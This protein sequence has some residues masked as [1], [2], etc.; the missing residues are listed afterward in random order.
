MGEEDGHAGEIEMTTLHTEPSNLGAST[1][2]SHGLLK[3]TQPLLVLQYFDDNS[4]EY[5]DVDSRSVFQ[6]VKTLL[7]GTL[8]L[9]QDTK[10]LFP[11]LTARDVRKLVSSVL[12]ASSDPT[13]VVRQ[14]VILLSLHP[15]NAIILKDSCLLLLQHGA[16]GILETFMDRFQRPHDKDDAEER[17]L[18]FEFRALDNILAAL[19]HYN[20]KHLGS[21][22]REA[23]HFIGRRMRRSI[24]APELETLR[25]LKNEIDVTLA[26]TRSIRALLT[27]LF[28]EDTDM[29]FMHLSLLSRQPDLFSTADGVTLDDVEELVDAYIDETMRLEGWATVLE[30]TIDGAESAIDLRVAATQRNLLITEALLTLLNVCI[31]LITTVGA[32]FG[33]SCTVCLPL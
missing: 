12:T 6:F 14:G 21:L 11:K 4:F 16:D 3:G 2:N 19:V 10:V 28:D 18:D 25:V 29:R 33:L 20:D 22:Q 23:D 31:T 13:L 1:S 8:L 9:G 15:F 5:P 26:R 7:G 30:K 32:I 27:D 17:L 24:G